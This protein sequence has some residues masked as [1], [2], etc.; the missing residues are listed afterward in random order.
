LNIMAQRGVLDVSKV[1]IHGLG[2]IL[3]HY[4]LLRSGAA[5]GRGCGPLIVARPGQDLDGLKSEVVGSPGKYTTAQLLLNLYLGE[6]GNPQFMVF[7]QIMP[8]LQRGEINYGLIIHEGRFT[9][10]DYGLVEL[11]DLGAWW[12]QETGLPIP[13]GGI[14]VKRS[15]G[16]GKAESM[17][18]AVRRSLVF[19]RENMGEAWNY[20]REHAQEM[21]QEAIQQHIDLYVNEETLHLSAEGERAVLALLRMARDK[22]IIN[23]FD[24]VFL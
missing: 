13:L 24:S 21:S 17:E 18:K 11:L 2:H 8:A 9:Y 14:A 7:D 23:D 3:D 12:E 10:R 5:L 1:S 22:N 6:T 20:I 15:L 19:G 16:A 4:A